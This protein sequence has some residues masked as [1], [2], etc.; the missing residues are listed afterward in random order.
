[1]IPPVCPKECEGRSESCHSTCEKYLEWKKVA[2]SGLD[3]VAEAWQYQSRLINNYRDRQ[4][5][6]RWH[7]K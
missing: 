6:K 5:K 4:R 2:S 3:K 7:M 1:M